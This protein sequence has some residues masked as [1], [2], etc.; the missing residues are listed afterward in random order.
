M[1][2][3]LLTLLAAATLAQTVHADTRAGSGATTRSDRTAMWVAI[4]AGAGFGLGLLA[5]LAAF[6]EARHSERK[7]WATAGAGGVAGGVTAWLL[8]RGRGQGASA[9]RTQAASKPLTEEEVRL[10]AGSVRLSPAATT[11]GTGRGF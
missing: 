4:G 1:R 9:A 7:I 2:T 8:S 3:F 5:G 6:D 10:L 11:A